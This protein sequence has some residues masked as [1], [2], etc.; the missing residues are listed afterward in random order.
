VLLVFYPKDKSFTCTSQLRKFQDHL[1]ALHA[2]DIEVVALNQESVVSHRAFAELLNI[3]FPILSDSDKRTCKAYKALMLGGL[4]V[5]RTVYLIDK[6]GKIRF[7]KRG[8]PG[9]T[10]IVS[11]L[12]KQFVFQKPTCALPS[13]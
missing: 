2:M 10:E 8:N 5:N 4:L 7:A 11:A 6:E 1:A 9:V 12:K 3:T 13:I